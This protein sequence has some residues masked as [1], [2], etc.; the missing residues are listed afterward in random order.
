MFKTILVAYDASMASA[1]AFRL[2][3]DLARQLSANLIVLS[4][5][6]LPEPAAMVE[7]SATLE[8][9]KEHYDKDFKRMRDDARSVGVELQTQIAV[10]HPAE[11]I[12]HHAAE[13]KADLVVMGHRGGS[14]VKEWLLGSVSKRVVT[15]APCSVLIA[16]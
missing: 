7:S 2:A 13:S 14:R 12:L 8:S 10:G 15:Y 16:R 11:Q 3:L 5:A 6:Q 4:V 1:H 9:A